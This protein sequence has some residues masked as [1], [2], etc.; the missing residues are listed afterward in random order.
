MI[1][2]K[3]QQNALAAALN[4][5]T[6]ASHKGTG[7]PPAFSLVRLEI[8]SNRLQ[9]TCFNGEFAACGAIPAQCLDSGSTN[10]SAITL[11]EIVQTMNSEIVLN[12][13]EDEV[14][15]KSGTN[16]A[17]LRSSA[18]ILPMVSAATSEAAISLKGSDLRK[19]ANT[20]LFA[21]TEFTRASLQGIHLTIMQDEAERL[22][23]Q[24]Q[25]ADGFCFGRIRVKPDLGPGSAMKAL[26]LPRLI[27][28]LPSDFL[29]T[30]A[31]VVDTDDEVL[32]QF[33]SKGNQSIFQ[34]RGE[35]RD[36]LF[37]T[38]MLQDEFPVSAVDE[39]LN[40]TL[41][42]SGAGLVI[43]NAELER[44]IRQVNAMGTKNLFIKVKSGL[45]RV[46]SNESEFG[47]AKNILAG[48]V[49]GGDAQVWVNT[50]LLLKLIKACP[51]EM[52]VKIGKPTE[53]ILFQSDDL[54]ALVMP[55]H[56]TSDP[57]EGDDEPAIELSLDQAVPVTA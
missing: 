56:D 6:K 46:A 51:A 17:H 26:S 4:I 27:S 47:Q 43:Q 28:G 39:L 18:E 37:V 2:I 42:A 24:A 53:P 16:R 49:S 3:I 57:F 5:V 20:A 10:V 9:L 25:S 54:L 23:L 32:V 13:S 48:E 38:A 29:K 30:L 33:P 55:L 8:S 31:T 12:V 44:V 21:S 14:L 34:I 19:L 11:R 41:S 15:I 36:F 52:S 1:E 22:I 35:S 45:I 50:D 40:K 7:S